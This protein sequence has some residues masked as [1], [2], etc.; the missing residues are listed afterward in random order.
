MKHNT[1]TALWT[2]LAALLLPALVGA[3]LLT[4]TGIAGHRS[5]DKVAMAEEQK[6]P[7]EE[8]LSLLDHLSRL[9]ANAGRTIEE[10]DTSD[11]S[12]DTLLWSKERTEEEMV[13]MISRELERR[14]L[15]RA[16][17]DLSGLRYQGQVRR[18]QLRV[19]SEGNGYSLLAQLM[20]QLADKGFD[21][22]RELHL[23]ELG[24]ALKAGNSDQ[25]LSMP[26]WE[27]R[28]SE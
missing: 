19:P 26:E 8:M 10:Y 27:A 11:E 1:H 7:E 20:E 24:Q 12:P 9:A 6:I 2:R 23:R 17:T 4:G 28:R 15:W 16:T 14:E 22:L 18:W 25:A 21:A 13:R 3:G 5:I